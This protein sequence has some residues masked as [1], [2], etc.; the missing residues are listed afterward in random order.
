MSTTELLYGPKPEQHMII[1]P[2]FKTRTLVIIFA[3]GGVG[4]TF[5]SLYLAHC[6]ATMNSFLRWRP[7]KSHIVLYFDGEMGAAELASR[8]ER[9][10][11]AAPHSVS[12]DKLRWVLA[13]SF[14]TG[15]LPNLA[16]VVGQE[17]Y[18]EEIEAAQADVV[19]ID[20]L[21]A[22]SFPIKGE[23]EATMWLPIQ[24]WAY[25]QKK[26]GRL[27]ILI[28]HA[29]KAGQIYGSSRKRNTADLVLELR[30][31]TV[32]GHAEDEEWDNAFELHFDKGRY[33]P[34]A[35][36][37]PLWV[38]QQDSP[39]GM[40]FKSKPLI[41]YHMEIISHFN[42]ASIYD[43]AVALGISPQQVAYLRAKKAEKSKMIGRMDTDID[44]DMGG[45]FD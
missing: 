25:N 27:V 24:A 16:S 33:L 43:T 1:D 45:Y 31:P 9:M 29:N 28:D 34:R 11:E 21:Q 8:I 18:N 15:S 37:I 10:E 41:D 7:E 3:E 5:F 22:C 19:V 20:N 12:P 38:E 2:L 30:P 4:K 26:K 13:E 23:S 35:E 36:K 17:I 32:Y 6:I 39:E 42:E 40:R 14:S 44:I